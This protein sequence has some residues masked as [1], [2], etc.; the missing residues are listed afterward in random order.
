MMKKKQIE[1]KLW[2]KN[3]DKLG[4]SSLKSDKALLESSLPFCL[5]SKEMSVLVKQL[6]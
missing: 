5:C 3:V 2:S 6:L 1:S 4:I